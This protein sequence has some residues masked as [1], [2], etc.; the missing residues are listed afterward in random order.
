MSYLFKTYYWIEIL[1][2]FNLL[3]STTCYAKYNS[4]VAL[5]SSTGLYKLAK[6][7]T[8]LTPK[9]QEVV[10][11]SSIDCIKAPEATETYNWWGNSGD[12]ESACPKDYPLA[13]AVV[14]SIDTGVTHGSIKTALLCCKTI[15][16][17]KA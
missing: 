2:L 7:S 4:H 11:D 6:H 3:I 15:V 16:Q 12:Q 14:G 5:T 10:A 1:M 8:Y 9:A 13:K 17:Y